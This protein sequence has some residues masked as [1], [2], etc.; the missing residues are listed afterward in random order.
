M[1]ISRR[2]A[3]IGFMG[4]LGGLL[5]FLLFGMSEGNAAGNAIIDPVTDMELAFI[6]EGCYQMG[7]VFGDGYDTEK[8]VHEVCIDDFYMGKYEV[9]QAQWLAV[10]GSNPSSFTGNSRPVENVSWNDAQNFIR[11][12]NQKSG[13]KYRLPTE[14]E[15]E[16]AA[17][18]GGKKEKY[19][20]SSSAE[21]G[22]W[23]SDNSGQKTHFV[24]QKSA[25]GLGLYDMSGNV[26]E[27]C[28]DGFSESFYSQS[29]RNNPQGP[30]AD[31]DRVSRGGSWISDQHGVRTARRNINKR[32]H[33]SNSIGFRLVHP[34]DQSEDNK[35]A[36][37][38]PQILTAPEARWE[39][40]ESE[41][42]AFVR[43]THHYFSIEYQK[44]QVYLAMFLG[45]N[46]PFNRAGDITVDG[47][48][49]SAYS[50]CTAG[51]TSTCG[52]ASS[53]TFVVAL[54]LKSIGQLQKG[55]EL[56]GKVKTEDGRQYDLRVPLAGSRAAIQKA[57]N[58]WIKKGTNDLI[59]AL[60]HRD[61][62]MVDR[63]LGKGN[64]NINA[65]D[66]EGRT[67]L[68]IIN[69]YQESAADDERSF[70]RLLVRHGADI[71]DSK[72]GTSFADV[73]QDGS[74]DF[75][76]FLLEQ[77][78]DPN[79]RDS[80]G[81]S[82]LHNSFT[83]DDFEKIYKMLVAAGADKYAKNKKGLTL[84]HRAM[85]W[86]ESMVEFLLAQRF[87][88]NRKDKFGRTAL[89]FV[90]TNKYIVSNPVGFIPRSVD[91][92]TVKLLLKNNAV[93]DKEAIRKHLQRQLLSDEDDYYA[94]NNLEQLDRL[95]Q[96][97]IYFK[98]KTSDH[99]QV[100]IRYKNLQG[101]W[102]TKSWFKLSPGKRGRVAIS[103]NRI[104]YYYAE[105]GDGAWVWEGDDKFYYVQGRDNQK[106]FIKKTIS[107]KKRGGEYTLSFTD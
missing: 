13:R 66:A 99:V 63:Y 40:V 28:V 56:R 92:D 58:I 36:H 44:N 42:V 107:Q 100:A 35:P 32:D 3:G 17:R 5:L 64:F 89:F 71:N 76:R 39:F 98:N 31:S 29:P 85:Q 2:P 24:G 18:S 75:I 8:P 102:V 52:I 80:S 72:L 81:N 33:Q 88:V 49:L 68:S 78:A 43:G 57:Q 22:A 16:Y 55:S 82:A 79:S 14:A 30:A 50:N 38:K 1:N 73:T 77:G 97:Y 10:M 84:L 26:W 60:L 54:D 103:K 47:K 34:A 25:N 12:L 6:K 93:I 51:I 27:W 15:W 91:Y 9:T 69:P 20:G 37:E 45:S 62:K 65:A 94:S 87:D 7:D 67:P 105:T 59:F 86:S 21:K 95:E 101:D 4:L 48:V 53:T 74:V 11:K 96:Y 83:N 23:Y 41:P 61:R 90:F 106:G 104:F 70:I 46:S 19:A